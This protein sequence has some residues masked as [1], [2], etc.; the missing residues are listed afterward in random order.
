MNIFIFEGLLHGASIQCM[1]NLTNMKL[2]GQSWTKVS[3]MTFKTHGDYL[4]AWRCL[5]W[6]D[7]CNTDSPQCPWRL[8]RPLNAVPFSRCK[9]KYFF[10]H[11]DRFLK[12]WERK[13]SP[14]SSEWLKHQVTGS[15]W[16]HSPFL[17][18]LYHYAEH[19]VKKRKKNKT[20][21]VGDWIF[22]NTSCFCHHL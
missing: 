20:T 22:V 7:M 17:F 4:N 6:V 15:G 11:T 16:K 5:L 19:N 2:W 12:R 13:F 10:F 14:V 1:I 18:E 8:I 21:L 9:N 3:L